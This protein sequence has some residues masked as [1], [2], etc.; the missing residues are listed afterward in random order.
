MV[1][2][3]LQKIAIDRT[4]SAWALLLEQLPKSEDEILSSLSLLQKI[5]SLLEKEFPNAEK[6]IRPGFDGDGQI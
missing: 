6:F 3:K 2:Q 1:L 5:K 4:I